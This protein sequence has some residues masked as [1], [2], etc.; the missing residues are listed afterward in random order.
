VDNRGGDLY[1]KMSDPQ[2]IREPNDPMDHL[3]SLR[4]TDDEKRTWR[5][6]AYENIP[7]EASSLTEHQLLLLCPWFIAFALGP[8]EWIC[9]PIEALHP[10]QRMKEPMKRLVIASK[11]L[12]F[13]QSLAMQSMSA[14][15]QWTADFVRGKGGGHLVLLHGPPGT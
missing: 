4:E 10:I 9:C 8:K 14:K 7:L 6:S 15:P 13:L 11:G 12:A 5:W 1:S 2:D 3:Q